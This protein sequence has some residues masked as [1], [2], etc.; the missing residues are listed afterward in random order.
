MKIYQLTQASLSEIYD[1][2]HDDIFEDLLSGNPVFTSVEKAKAF[3]QKAVDDQGEDSDEN[4]WALVWEQSEDGTWHGCTD[5]D[6]D[7][8]STCFRILECRL[9]P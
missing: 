8:S 1:F 7:D 3:A 5:E 6:C 4:S 9:D 2:G